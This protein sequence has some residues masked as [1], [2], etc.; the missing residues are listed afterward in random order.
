MRLVPLVRRLSSL[1]I[2]ALLGLAPWVVPQSTRSPGL[3]AVWATGTWLDDTNQDGFNDRASVA[4]DLGA[5]PDAAAVAAAA[6]VAA[7]VGYETMSLDLPLPRGRA[8]HGL[9]IGGHSSTA[10]AAEILGTD[11]IPAPGRGWVLASGPE[12]GGLVVSLGGDDESGLQSASLYVA[13]RLPYLWELGARTL[14]E[15][16]E[17]IV[18]GLGAAGWPAGPARVEGVR[19]EAAVPGVQALLLR[20]SVDGGLP[21]V[22]AGLEAGGDLV[23]G[24]VPDGVAELVLVIESGAAERVVRLQGST[25]VPD[26]DT[27]SR[28]GAGGRARISLA[29]LYG[30]DGLLGDRNSDLIP[31]RLDVL[32]SP[33]DGGHEAIIDLADRLGLESA[34]LTLP[35]AAPPG[36]IDTPESSPTLLLV[37]DEHPLAAE[38]TTKAIPAATFERA[39]A[40]LLSVPAA[41]DDKTA[42]LVRGDVEAANRVL[43]YMA[44]ALPWLG[45]RGKD[46]PT[47]EQVEHDLWR[48]L[49]RRSPAGQAADAVRLSDELLA[50]V[51][52]GA[53]EVELSVAVEGADPGLQSFLRRKINGAANVTVENLDVAAA[54]PI[55][56]GTLHIDSEVQSLTDIVE[57]TVLPAVE[58]GS[59]VTVRA[60]ISEPLA[61]RRRVAADLRDRLALAGAAAPEVEVLPAYKQGLGWIEEVLIPRL[62]GR[63]VGEV[64]IR[65]AKAEPPE[66]WPYQS[67]TAPSR[68]LLELFPVDEMIAERLQIELAQVRYE[69]TPAGNPIYEVIA[70]SDDGEVL[71]H[72]SFDPHVVVQPYFELFPRYE[73][74]RVTTGWVQAQVDGDTLLDERLPTDVERVWEHYQHVVLPLLHDYVMRLHEGVPRAGRAPH[75]SELRIE[76]SLSEPDRQLGIDREQISPMESL[77]EELYFGT[78]HFMDLVGRIATGQPLAYPGRVIPI[79]RPRGDGGP[80]TASFRLTG[81]T[82]PGPR[83]ELTWLDSDGR[84]QRLR[85]D[86]WEIDIDRPT[87]L[88]ATFAADGEMTGID[89]YVEVDSR[90]DRR[91][92]LVGRTSARRVDA[93][94]LSGAQLEATVGALGALR[95]AGV[96]AGELA[97]D[98]IGTLRVHW[99]TAHAVEIAPQDHVELP[100][101]GLPPAL[102]DPAALL[103]ASPRMGPLVQWETPI[104]PGEA[105]RVLATMDLEFD[106]ASAYRISRSYLGKE[107]WALDIMAPLPGSHWS[108]AKASAYKPTVVYSARQHANEVSSTSHVLRMAEQ[109]L[110]DPELAEARRRLN[111][112]VHP[113]TNPDG[114]QLAYDLYGITPD[115][116]L[117]AGYLGS[118]GVDV[119]AGSSDEDPIYPESSV[120]ERLWRTWLPDIFLN[121]HGYPSHEWVQLFSEYAAWVRHRVTQSRGWWGMRGWF[122]PGFAWLDDPDYPRHAE[123]AFRIRDHITRAINALPEIVSLNERAYHR[124][125]RYGAAFDPQAFKLDFSDDVLI[126]TSIKGARAGGDGYMTRNPK[127]TIWSGSTEAP[128]ET[129]HG[130]WLQLVASAGLAWDRAILEYLLGLEHPVERSQ[131]AFAGGLDLSSY[132]ERPGRPAEDGTRP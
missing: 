77:H 127:V 58:A 61:I 115:H 91:S 98:G 89:A 17:G 8:A 100:A 46:R 56:T 16:T 72:E 78:L 123:H 1:L 108:Q 47:L 68:W 34:G 101:G 60:H 51:P 39:A 111:V 53:T 45:P 38:I 121:P 33:G 30:T 36:L 59:A 44:T 74:V 15:V 94:W 85:R 13:G 103:P 64:I 129:A 99:G 9:V 87:L 10:R 120:R 31:D 3:E 23:D 7:R 92:E 5:E 18:A 113:I 12:L 63:Q 97:Y 27:G 125:R 54:P 80:G 28:P 130:D 73:Q 95:S 76:V 57:S 114:A 41:F 48:F 117:H 107:I 86:L 52:A 128:D 40:A 49:S 37:G 19:V 25:E 69:E 22:V 90:E 110:S 55:H 42:L 79:V 93:S 4:F 66:G 65:F 104:P 106:F 96:H 132:R 116:M 20:V 70:T 102:P 35:V 109:L 2:L 119:T 62:E 122:M 32:L 88:G 84:A 43:T 29:G 124:Y 50:E 131:Q 81:F 83:V 21:A 71:L 118:L 6:N 112:V 82:A 24:L 11:G 26:P 105:N 14:E 75:F 126:Y 67:L